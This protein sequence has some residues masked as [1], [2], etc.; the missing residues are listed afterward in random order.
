ME[1][2]SDKH[3]AKVD[4]DMRKEFHSVQQANR[5]T[6]QHEELEAEPLVDDDGRPATD[7]EARRDDE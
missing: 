2:G 6:R 5:P 4:D 7:P 1:R 3:S